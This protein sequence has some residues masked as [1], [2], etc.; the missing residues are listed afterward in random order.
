MSSRRFSR[1]TNAFSKKM[2]NHLAALHLHFA[3]YNFCRVH[4][5]LKMTPALAAG[6][7]DHIWTTEELVES[8]L[9]TFEAGNGQIRT[10]KSGV[11]D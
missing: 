6:I 7:T 9:Q 5:S 11:A 10:L 2:E 1:K 4:R 8:A 3:Y